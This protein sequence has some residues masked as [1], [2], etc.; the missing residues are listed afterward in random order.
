MNS[1]CDWGN[2]IPLNVV[3][4]ALEMKRRGHPAPS[5]DKFIF[6]NPAAFLSQSPKFKLPEVAGPAA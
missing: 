1:A 4:T 2:S 6:G 3:Y 5:I